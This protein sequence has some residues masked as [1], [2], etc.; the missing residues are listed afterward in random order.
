[1]SIVAAPPEPTRASAPLRAP[2][3]RLRRRLGWD[4]VSSALSVIIAGGA[5][6]RLIG[7]SWGLPLELHPDEWVVVHGAI[8]MAQSSSFEPPYF[9]RPDHVEMEL[10]NLAYLAYSYLWHSSSPQKMY[11]SNPAPFILISRTITAC[12]GVAMIVVAYL[13]GKRFTRVVAVL[14]AFLVAF[15][16][17]FVDN[18][19]FATPDV[20]LSFAFMIVILGCMRYLSQPS[21]ANLLLAC[22]GVSVATAIKYPGALGALMIAIVVIVSGVRARQWSR[23]FVHGAAAISAVIGFL[24]AISPVLFTNFGAVRSN[25]SAEAGSTH[26]GADGWGWSQNL[27]FYAQG[28]TNS[29]GIV[30][31]ACF[32]LGV[33]WSIR[34]RLLQS[35]PL[36]T[37]AIVWVL[38]SSLPLHWDRWGLPMF[39]TPLLMAPLGAYYSFQYVR[40][41]G[42]PTWQRWQRRGVACLGALVAANL[43][44]GSVAVS[45]SY[46]AQNTQSLA[47]DLA[48]RGID[49]SSAVVDGYTPLQVGSYQDIFD[50]FEVLNG[51]LMLRNGQ[52]SSATR[53][54][55]LSSSV[56][57]R[58][59]T[60]SRYA[61]EQRFYS[62]LDKQFPLV[63]TL[64]NTPP[65]TPTALEPLSIWNSIGY[66]G[67][68][69][70]GGL[71]GPK[72]TVHEIPAQN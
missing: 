22:L 14:A 21:W 48:V 40:D 66:V 17:P 52:T 70:Q 56:D 7:D 36:W 47:K 18:S 61:T 27:G 15:F 46:L 59:A 16:P 10:S 34:L 60:D 42:A 54:V 33:L 72:I 9:F 8:Q 71:V 13:I 26:T 65:A 57:D 53:Y 5:V 4:W 63:T 68:L 25:L 11:A 23:I 39:L 43:M 19:H 37:G 62:M 31:L 58:F 38:L 44:G 3:G 55:V 6:A 35:V 2:R 28:F 67:R 12:F 30:V 50:K 51:R 69:A 49:L 64:D 32:A 20:P 24:F 29:A 45:A 1:M 41:R